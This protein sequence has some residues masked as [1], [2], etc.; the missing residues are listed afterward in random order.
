VQLNSGSTASVNISSVNGPTGP[1]GSATGTL[2]K[3][4]YVTVANNVYNYI[5]SN[6]RAPNYASSSLGNIRYE[7]LVYAYARIVNFYRVNVRLPD[8]VA[9]SNIVGVDSAGVVIDTVAPTVSNNL[10]SGSYNTVKNVT[11]TATDH[12][13]VNPKIYYSLNNG[14]WNNKAKTVTLTL[15]QGVTTLKYY[16]RDAAGNQGATQTRTYTIDTNVPNFNLDILEYAASSVT[17]YI[18]ANHKLPDN[19]TINGTTVNMAQFLKLITVATI[20]INS[21]TNSSIPLENYTAAPNPS[22]TITTSG[23]LNKTDYLNVASY[24]SNF[25]DTNGRVP[26]CKDTVRGVIRYESLVYIYAQILNSA[27]NKL[28]LPDYITLT[29]WT[30]ITNQKH[31][32]YKYGSDKRRDL[33]CEKLC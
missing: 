30:T 9:I 1:S 19:V 27:S 21:S 25:M 8:S 28:R 33:G 26:N 4:E 16:G 7:S 12:V 13:D 6:G 20:N 32:V 24:I 22:E 14:T 15:N 31:C 5:N 29:P 10:A 18:E 11:L 3:S 23:N 17:T 2:Y